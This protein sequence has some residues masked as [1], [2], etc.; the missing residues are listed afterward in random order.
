[1]WQKT[2]M[3]VSAL[4][5]CRMKQETNGQ[6][7]NEYLTKTILLAIDAVAITE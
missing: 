4:K 3:N 1:M 6:Y 2:L 7:F 5:V